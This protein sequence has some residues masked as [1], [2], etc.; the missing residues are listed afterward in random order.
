MLDSGANI[1]LLRRDVWDK[2]QP[3]PPS[4]PPPLNHSILTAANNNHITVQLISLVPTEFIDHAR[5]CTY[6]K[7]V[8]YHV[9]ADLGPDIL[10]GIPAMQGIVHN[11]SIHL[12][13]PVFYPNLK[14]NS[15][16]LLNSPD[17]P[18]VSPLIVARGFTLPPFGSREVKL[19]YSPELESAA[20]A[21]NH[22]ICCRLR[23]LH[24]RFANNIKVTFRAHQFPAGQTKSGTYLCRVY[25]HSNSVYSLPR[26]TQLGTATHQSSQH[27]ETAA[28]VAAFHSLYSSSLQCGAAHAVTTGTGT[29]RRTR[30]RLPSPP[31]FQLEGDQP[32]Q[33]VVPLKSGRSLSYS[34]RPFNFK[35]VR[36]YII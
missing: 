24:S 5:N 36:P 31:K 18:L 21:V 6:S 35:P 1:N 23:E 3:P 17:Q 12:L 10:L 7:I 14:S 25:N 9:C 27:V 28:E 19:A 11:L 4:T 2:I 8:E 13:R 26:N 22:V 16:G 30:R 33:V 32:T 15:L 34:P 29:T 20:A